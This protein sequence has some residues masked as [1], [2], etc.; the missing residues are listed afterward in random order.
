MKKLFTAIQ[1]DDIDTI[2]AILDKLPELIG[3]V[4]NGSP[5]RLVGQSPLQ[6][7]LKESNNDTVELLLSYAPDVNFMEDESCPNEWRAPV[8]HDA[9]NR[10]VMNSRFNVVRENGIEVFNTKEKADRSFDILCKIIDMGADANQKDSYGNACLDR[11]CLQATQILPQNNS[12][13]RVLTDELEYDISRI[14]ELLIKNGA[15]LNYIAPNAFGQTY[16]QRYENETV[17]KYLKTN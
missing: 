12:S 5:K 10:A 17:A 1:K 9:I 2:K 14:F 15:D 16:A 6:V 4:L 3:S 13:G 8:L 11:A 7:A